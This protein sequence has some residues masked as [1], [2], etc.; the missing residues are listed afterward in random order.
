MRTP[1]RLLLILGILLFGGWPAMLPAYAPMQPS[2]PF[3][4]Q[5][6]PLDSSFLLVA[7]RK[8]ADPRFRET[9]VV[10]T[11]VRHTGPIGIVINRPGDVTLDK[12]FPAYPEARKIRLFAGGPVN[13]QHVSYLFRGEGGAAGTLKISDGVCLSYDTTLLGDLLSGARAHTGLRVANGLAAWAPGQL[14]NEIA[15]GD[16]YVLPIDDKV[17]FDSPEDKIWPELFRKATAVTH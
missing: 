17:I 6:A 3:Q 9:V 13:P 11:R 2:R 7:S 1:F 10:V 15:R 12:L 4:L 14:E 8:L 16:W 5:E